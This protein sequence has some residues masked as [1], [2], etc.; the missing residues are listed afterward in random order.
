MNTVQLVYRD[1]LTTCEARQCAEASPGL[2]C[3]LHQLVYGLLWLPWW[4]HVDPPGPNCQHHQTKKIRSTK[5]CNHHDVTSS[6][7]QRDNENHVINNQSGSDQA[8]NNQS[9]SDRY[10]AVCSCAMMASSG[11]DISAD[12][13]WSLCFG[14]R[15]KTNQK[16]LHSVNDKCS[17]MP[18][19]H[20][21]TSWI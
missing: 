12:L 18:H 3:P 6:T 4:S 10:R 7:P 9:G 14:S 16:K 13:P 21:N 8:I 1:K 2:G 15:L 5:C 20:D 11:Q 19:H 17:W